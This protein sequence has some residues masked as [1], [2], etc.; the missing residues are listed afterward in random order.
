M[1]IDELINFSI[2]WL[3]CHFS[4]SIYR[5]IDWKLW[6]IDH[7]AY[8]CM[9]YATH[10]SISLS[11][12]QSGPWIFYDWS[13][14]HKFDHQSSVILI[15]AIVW[16]LIDRGPFT[17]I[18]WALLRHRA[19]REKSLLDLSCGQSWPTRAV[20]TYSG[21][22]CPVSSPLAVHLDLLDSCHALCHHPKPKAPFKIP[23][24]YLIPNFRI[25]PSNCKQNYNIFWW[26]YQC[27][28]CR[29]ASNILLLP[30]TP[31]IPFSSA[32]ATLSCCLILP[33]SLETGLTADGCPLPDL[34]L[35]I[36]G[37]TEGSDFVDGQLSEPFAPGS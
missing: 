10:C 5:F 27:V 6:F 8:L 15:K 37:V 11:N 24:L 32:S 29:Y 12:F 26:W 21:L 13:H 20:R 16:V 9:G 36:N 22:T 19:P 33:R 34:V 2:C 23:L 30:P 17:L 35:V 1:T 3:W 14:L 7:R 18:P 25:K 4:W 28:L 31:T